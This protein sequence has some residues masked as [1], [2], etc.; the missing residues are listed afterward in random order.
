M[1][2]LPD[3]QPFQKRMINRYIHDKKRSTHTAVNEH[4]KNEKLKQRT[5][6]V[7]SLLYSPNNPS[8]TPRLCNQDTP[9]FDDDEGIK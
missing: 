5:G 8:D 9:S 6:G 1:N 7:S 2:Q 4:D 3:Y